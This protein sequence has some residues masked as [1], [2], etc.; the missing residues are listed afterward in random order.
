MELYDI[1]HDQDP[2]RPIESQEAA[3]RQ[4]DEKLRQLLTQGSGKLN[5]YESAFTCARTSFW[6][7][8]LKSLFDGK[9]HFMAL[10]AAH[11]FPS[12]GPIASCPGFLND[13]RRSGLMVEMVR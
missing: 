11:L 5:V 4:V 1:D 2:E 12:S 13:L 9:V 6:E 3:A 8:R 10:G 7:R